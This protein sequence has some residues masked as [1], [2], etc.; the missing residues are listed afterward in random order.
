M[1]ILAIVSLMMLMLLIYMQPLKA[2]E[3]FLSLNFDADP[4][5]PSWSA[6]TV[7][8][9][10]GV[11]GADGVPTKGLMLVSTGN[12]KARIALPIERM[13][14][15]KILVSAMVKAEN[16]SINKKPYNGLKLM[17]VYVAG[18]KKYYPAAA[19]EVGSFNWKNVFFYTDI[20][21]NATSAELYIGLEEV[22]GTAWYDDIKVESFDQKVF[23]VF[24]SEGL[25]EKR[26]FKSM[27]EQGTITIAATNFIGTVNPL[28][29]GANILGEDATV[30]RKRARPSYTIKSTGDGVWDPV[31]KK[32]RTDAAA[33]AKE[34]SIRVVRY[35]GGCCVHGFEW[36]K[37]VGPVTKRPNYKFG[38]PEFLQWCQDI[39][40]IPVM[41]VSDYACTPEEAGELVEFLNAPADDSHPWAKKRAE[42]GHPLPYRVKYFELGNETY[43]G[44]HD[45][46]PFR[47]M[48]ASEY[49]TWVLGCTKAMR[50]ADEKISVG[51]VLKHEDNDWNENVLKGTKDAADFVIYHAYS[52]GLWSESAA[53]FA[54][55]RIMRGCLVGADQ[56][57]QN[58]K[59]ISS[60]TVRLTGRKI[61]IA[62]T[63]YNTACVQEKP[64]PYRW[65]YGSAFF[66]ADF[67]RV[68]LKTENNVLMGNYWQYINSYWG[69]LQSSSEAENN[70]LAGKDVRW[71]KMPAFYAFRLWGQHTG[72][73]IVSTTIQS[74]KI[75]FE[76]YGNLRPASRDAITAFAS[77][78]NDGKTICLMVFNRHPANPMSVT[79]SFKDM[80][81]SSARMWRM[82]S[83][84]LTNMN[85][86]RETA[87]ETVSDAS[88]PIAE[89]VISGLV[90]P[91]HSITALEIQ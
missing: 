47:A 78:R 68:M 6:G 36:K 10:V 40:A 64:I 84:H 49:N 74:P 2:N 12:N 83:E 16:V 13:R 29:F 24:K 53:A 63:E 26:I 87:K 15:K 34:L 79:I 33:F 62:V 57:E 30:I 52:I 17:I 21:E 9:D 5:L 89:G 41:T 82:N 45:M 44:N 27:T 54:V 3:V 14:G 90:L 19:M 23:D 48:N 43:H 77:M 76:G 73:K 20:P 7:K 69:M 25:T 85:Y 58:L 8:L 1:K 75:D 18:G 38:I 70:M 71:K 4:N 86:V 56:F 31:K 65:T 42:G 32:S 55:D 39:G 11:P 46:V 72:E 80:A 59:D 35:P 60:M 66:N 22:T 61:P 81:I 67:F 88:V 50:K 37:T 51:V 91:K 28:V